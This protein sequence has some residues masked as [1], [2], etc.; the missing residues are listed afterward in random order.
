[1]ILS[2]SVYN[3]K[4]VWKMKDTDPYA[5]E[6]FYNGKKW[7]FGKIGKKEAYVMKSNSGSLPKLGLSNWDSKHKIA[8]GAVLREVSCYGKN[9]I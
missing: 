3:G 2:K 5:T 8:S 1:M 7:V 6:L 4:C 9:I